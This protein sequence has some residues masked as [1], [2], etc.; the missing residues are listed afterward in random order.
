M[1]GEAGGMAAGFVEHLVAKARGTASTIAP[2]LP[3]LF[4]PVVALQAPEKT[5]E[6]TKEETDAASAPAWTPAA[7]EVAQTVPDA[8]PLPVPPQAASR[9]GDR[10]GHARSGAAKDRIGQAVSLPD[11]NA[12][13]ALAAL[14]LPSMTTIPAPQPSRPRRADVDVSAVLEPATGTRH[15]AHTVAMGEE[16]AIP[17]QP[18]PGVDRPAPLP[19]DRP[20][21]TGILVPQPP[22]VALPPAALR[23][24]AES[25]TGAAAAEQS[26]PVINVTIGRVEVRAVQS[27]PPAARAS[28]PKPK[29]LGLDDYL[30]QRGGRR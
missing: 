20:Y 11:P 12:T 13:P 25:S 7:R 3:S 9:D 4:E 17:P 19:P 6:E 23:S 22:A 16:R 8:G 2:R 5:P 15:P 24:E 28:A 21:A 27:A 29:P 18:A 14:P 26:A 1:S 30:K 10:S